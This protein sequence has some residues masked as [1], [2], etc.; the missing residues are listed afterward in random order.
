MDVTVTQAADVYTASL[1]HSLLLYR[2]YQSIQVY[3]LMHLYMYT[4]QWTT[5]VQTNVAVNVNVV[6]STCRWTFYLMKW[7]II[8]YTVNFVCC[9]SV[10]DIHADTKT[11]VYK[12]TV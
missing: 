1:S 9:H 6:Y 11:S 7:I 2:P 3:I 5:I 8:I 4:V 12:V 10:S